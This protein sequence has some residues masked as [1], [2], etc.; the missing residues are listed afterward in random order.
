MKIVHRE[1]A[2]Q[3]ARGYIID[4]LQNE[5]VEHATIITSLKGAVR[6]NHYHKDSV[7]Y[8]YLLSGRLQVLAQMPGKEVESEIL[9]TGDLLVNVPLERHALIALE[10]SVFVV[11]TRGPRGGTQYESDTY[12][13]EHPLS[14]SD[15]VSQ[16]A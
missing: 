5:P 10:D 3:D 4:I 2:F 8:A 12:R 6:G 13:L 15:R 14:A 9:E 11:L 1:I 16:E 7:Q